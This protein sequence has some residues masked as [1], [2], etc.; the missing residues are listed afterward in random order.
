MRSG[1]DATGNTL[2]TDTNAVTPAAINVA[3]AARVRDGDMAGGECSGSGAGDRWVWD[4]D[5]WRMENMQWRTENDRRPPFPFPVLGCPLLRDG[6]GVPCG[7]YAGTG[8]AGSLR[9]LAAAIS[10]ALRVRRLA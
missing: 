10:A 7:G 1:T 8:V 3:T 2:A 6:A 9:V 5:Q 4:L